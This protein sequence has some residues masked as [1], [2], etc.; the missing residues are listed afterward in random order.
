L[1]EEELQLKENEKN[2]N[3]DDNN[4]T[5]TRR[6][7]RLIKNVDKN[8]NHF[9]ESKWIFDILTCP[10]FHDDIQKP[11]SLKFL[12][13][14]FLGVHIQSSTHDSVQDAISAMALYRALLLEIQHY[15]AKQ[16]IKKKVLTNHIKIINWR[17]Y[18]Q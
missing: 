14:L 8:L 2:N 5:S 18:K 1:F 3:D 12:T 15:L 6:V 11:K 17:K 13:E 4:T 9:D 7:K 10:L 16:K